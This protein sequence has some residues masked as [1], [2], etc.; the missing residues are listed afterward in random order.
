MANQ[1]IQF[2]F[3][4]NKLSSISRVP[5]SALPIVTKYEPLFRSRPV[6]HDDGTWSEYS[7]LK[8]DRINQLKLSLESAGFTCVNKTVGGR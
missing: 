7:D 4:G 1:P 3:I 5:T 6:K 8:Q 2:R